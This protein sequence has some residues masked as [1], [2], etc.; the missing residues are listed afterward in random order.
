MVMSLVAWVVLAGLVGA[1]IVGLRY[2]RPATLL[3]VGSI[4][5]TLGA[6]EAV[7]RLTY[8]PSWRPLRKTPSQAYHHADPPNAVL[9]E[10]MVKGKH[11]IVQTN[12]DG[13]RTAYSRQ[14]FLSFPDRIAVLGD[15]FTFGADVAQEAAFPQVMERILRKKRGRSDVAVLNAGTI[16]YS[17]LLAVRVFKGVIAQYKP[18][19]VLYLLDPTDIGDD[20]NYERE[21]VGKGAESHFEWKGVH[22]T[23][24]YGAVGQIARLDDILET[25][26]RPL[27]PVF[28]RW[29]LVEPEREYDWYDFHATI[30][31]EVEENRY[32][33]YRHPLSETQPYFDR[34]YRYITALAEAVK[35]S[36]AEFALVVSPR[37]HHWNPKEC[38]DNWEEDEYARDEPYQ[39]EYFRYFQEKRPTAGFEIFDLLPAFQATKGFPLVFRSDPHWNEAGHTF[40]A[41]VL[42]TYLSSQGWEEPDVL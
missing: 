41:Q 33:I 32:F 10:G 18:R 23:P 30:G 35:A 36:G 39:Y 16:S 27:G 40:V 14:E 31:G 13:F 3:A 21:L 7:L 11:V 34:T 9:Y 4:V 1:L 6:T 20:Y 38:P 28:R 5:F 37:F 8:P 17:P 22:V 42:V 12:E 24:Y 25:L 19:I 29:G 2:R 26:G 15:S